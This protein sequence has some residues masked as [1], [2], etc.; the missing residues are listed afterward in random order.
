MHTVGRAWQIPG[1]LHPRPAQNCPAAQSRFVLHALVPPS[2][3]PHA[4]ALRTRTYAAA[5]ALG[6]VTPSHEHTGSY[7]CVQ[8]G[9]SPIKIAMLTDPDGNALE[10]M[11]LPKGMSHLPH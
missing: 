11:E 3:S 8:I 1:T 4:P 10:I 5:H 2:G 6:N 9:G 7:C